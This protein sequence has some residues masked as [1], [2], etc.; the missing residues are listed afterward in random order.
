VVIPR[1]G[2]P[3]VAV[4]TG[5]QLSVSKEFFM[6]QSTPAEI[7]GISHS[8]P[9]A[10]PEILGISSLNT[11]RKWSL[12]LGSSRENSKVVQF[13]MFRDMSR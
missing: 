12:I 6:L 8:N 10:S 2:E 1:L 7:P 9:V 3:I 13:G 4:F 5:E 11:S